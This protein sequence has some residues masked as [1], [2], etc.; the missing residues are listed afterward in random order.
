LVHPDHNQLRLFNLMID[1][2]VVRTNVNA[3]TAPQRVSPGNHTVSETGGTGTSLSEFRTV[4]GGDC[5]A[6]GTVN[7]ALG[8][9]KTCTITNYDNFGGCAI[10]KVCCDPGDGTEGCL[11]C[12]RPGLCP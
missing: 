12:G 7:L 1:G 4:I 6:D 5:T 10:G 11:R 9:N 2:V 8:D 3:G